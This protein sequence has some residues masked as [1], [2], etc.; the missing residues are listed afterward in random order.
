MT[1]HSTDRMDESI[2]PWEEAETMTRDYQYEAI[3]LLSTS[4]DAERAKVAMLLAALEGLFTQHQEGHVTY[5]CHC[6]HWAAARAAI[7]TAKGE[8]A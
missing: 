8:S 2:T 1:S 5:V 3:E 7:R 6:P 4:L